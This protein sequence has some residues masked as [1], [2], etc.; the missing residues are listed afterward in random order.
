[1]VV[2]SAQ[3][4]SVCP[5]DMTLT[6]RTAASLCLRT[7]AKQGWYNFRWQGNGRAISALAMKRITILQSVCPVA[8][9]QID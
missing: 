6:L 4:E 5:T 7:A 2:I 3:A 9:A 1:M 8:A